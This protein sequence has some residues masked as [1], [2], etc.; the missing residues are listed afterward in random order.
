MTIAHMRAAYFADGLT[1]PDKCAS[2]LTP[3]DQLGDLVHE[4]LRLSLKPGEYA[5][6]YLF[7]STLF[8]SC[9]IKK[10]LENNIMETILFICS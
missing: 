4:E 5:S 6:R 7:Y 1:L 3:Q 8:A 2:S 9:Y 10:T